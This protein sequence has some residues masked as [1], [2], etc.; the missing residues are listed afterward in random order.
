MRNSL[1]TEMDFVPTPDMDG[2]GLGLG[3]PACHK[4]S[5]RFHEIWP[6]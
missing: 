6:G 1:S 5:R 3:Q 2:D 4:I